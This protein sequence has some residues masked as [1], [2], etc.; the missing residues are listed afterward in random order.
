MTRRSL[1]LL[2]LLLATAAGAVYLRGPAWTASILSHRLS[3]FFHRP[4]T[5]GGVRYGFVP[6]QIEITGLRVA[7]ATPADEPFLE[8]PRV[9]VI[10]STAA[11]LDRRLVLTR[12]VVERPLVRVRAFRGGGDDLPR[13]GRP[14]PGREVQ[15]RRLVIAGGELVLDH[16]RVP[17]DLDLPD[18]GGR[19]VQRRPGVLA[20]TVSFGPGPARFGDAPALPLATRI[21]LAVE[22]TTVTI[23]SAR[24]TGEK[25]DLTYRGRLSLSPRISAE[26]GVAGE[27]DL[28]ILDRHVLASD[29]GLEG[30]GRFRGTVRHQD[31]RLRVAGRLEGTGGS[32][33]GVTVPRYAGDVE[34]DDK[35]I[36]LSGLEVAL[37]GGSGRFDVE[38]PPSPGTAEVDA[39]LRGVD[40][41]DLAAWLFDV[42]KA[43]LG[44]GATGTISARWPRGRRRAVSGRASLLLE[45]RGDGRTPLRG[46]LSWRAQDGAQFVEQ[47]E[48]GT[49][50]AQVRL[51]GPIAADRRTDLELEV[52][53][54]DLASADALLVRLRRALGAAAPEPAGLSG[55]GVFEGRWTGRLDDPVFEGRFRGQEVGYLGVTWGVA[56]AVGALDAREVRPRSLVL[57][58]PGGELWVDGRVET[59]DYGDADGIDARVRIVSWPGADLVKA[60]QWDVPFEGLVSG[61]AALTGR[62]SDPHGT[63]HLSSASGRYFGVAFEDLDVRSVLRGRVT[64]VTAGRAR[65]GG[66]PVE[67]AGVVTD[68]GIYDGRAHAEDV[69]VSSLLPADTSYPAWG[70]RVSGSV[71]LQGPLARPR[72]EG[73]VRSA[74]LSLAGESLGA[75]EGTFAGTGDGMVGLDA[76]CLAPGLDLVLGGRVGVARPYL[77]DLTA[78]TLQTSL[79]PLLRAAGTDVPAGV[80]VVATGAVRLRGPLSSPRDLVAEA[81][82]QELAITLPDYPVR[83]RAPVRLRVADATLYVQRLELSGEGTDLAVAGRAALTGDGLV[84]FTVRGNADLRVLSLVSAELRGRGAARVEVAVS[85]PRSAPVVDGS[86]DVAGAG[87]RLRGFP[88]G[89]EDVR[90]RVLFDGQAAHFEGV[91]GTVGGGAVELQGQ[92]AYGGGRLT[93]FDVSATGRAIALRYPEGLRSVLD[94]SLRLFGDE[95]QQWLT[96]KVDVR[97]AVWTRRYD[98]ASELLASTAPAAAEANLGGGVRYDV[99]VLAPGTLRIDNNLTTLQARAELTLQGTYETPVVLGRAEIDR[100]RV[101]FQGNTYVIRRGTIDFTDP[102]RLD[103]LFDVEAETRVRSYNVTLKVN[104]TL[105]RVYP[106]LSSD[107]P[108][109]TVGIL[110]LLA[111]AEESDVEFATQLQDDPQRL[112]A[113]GAATLAAGKLSE[114]VGLEKGAARLGLSRFSIDPSVVR[115]EVSNPT[116]RMTLGKRI[117]PDLNV[118]Y[119]QDLRG[120]EERLVA[121]EYTLSD[122]LSVLI[123]QSQPGGYGFDLRLRRQSR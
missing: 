50:A 4:V 123:T 36:R 79:D 3:A 78:T 94:A 7:G 91:T 89:V 27:V 83:N 99:K 87:V 116:A 40:A 17:L 80:G 107:P 51:R 66:G 29:L 68:D 69:D 55:A 43:G 62:R 33:G 59:G 53:S 115:G 25:T 104:G 74:R 56:E 85:G 30:H 22:G 122:R 90:G 21:D 26:L 38:V 121:I 108:L 10:P 28:A 16:Q 103:P 35:G 120:T 14:G 105:E 67:F 72:V 73:K 11:L 41:E 9:L 52:R 32:F 2:A 19:L 86:L 5:V 65:V 77:A 111:G 100:G 54:T 18:V 82:V 24:L 101:Y 60:L 92:A 34:W 44:A 12:V 88:H 23:E 71:V 45:P 13:L 97:D 109:S 8:V 6:L 61:E 106:V 114:Q 48:F 58:R 113:A 1:L 64:E 49:L 75:M 57:R 15:I 63:A 96:G 119:S 81:E 37:M 117:T 46:R 118:V 98:V 102:R 39:E 20:G 95:S 42:G 47:G 70:G 84:D 112:A 31:G 76:R 93:S 110:S